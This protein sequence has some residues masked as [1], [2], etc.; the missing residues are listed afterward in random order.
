MSVERMMKVIE[1]ET[2]VEELLKQ[3]EYIVDRIKRNEQYLTD[4][5]I[6]EVTSLTSK[7]LDIIERINE[8]ESKQKVV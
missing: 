5:E 1:M 4:V 3:T 2:E 8:I 7:A 6:H